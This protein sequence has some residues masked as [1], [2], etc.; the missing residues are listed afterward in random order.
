MKIKKIFK[1][2]HIRIKNYIT[3]DVIEIEKHKFHE[4]KNPI[5]IGAVYIN[6]LIVSN[7]VLFGKNGFKY[8][9][10]YEDKKRLDHY[11]YGRNFDDTKY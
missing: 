8:F 9:I 7:K 1:Y 2:I 10:G 6:K 5:S 4:R 11:V 3:F